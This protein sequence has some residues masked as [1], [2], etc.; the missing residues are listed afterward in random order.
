MLV[1][2]SIRCTNF[3]GLAYLDLRMQASGCILVEGPNEAG[4]SSVLDAVRFA[5][6]GLTPAGGTPES[7][8]RTGASESTVCVELVGDRHSIELERVIS[9]SKRNVVRVAMRDGLARSTTESEDEAADRLERAFGL[10][11]ENLNEACFVGVDDTYT[12]PGSRQS[13]GGR[14]W[15]PPRRY[16]LRRVADSLGEVSDF[17][18]DLEAARERLDL[19]QAG[20]RLASAED[21]VAALQRMLDLV[22]IH[23]ALVNLRSAEADVESVRRAAAELEDDRAA[24]REELRQAERLA[25]TR[26]LVEA[27]RGSLEADAEAAGSLVSIETEMDAQRDSVDDGAAMRRRLAV[28]NEARRCLEEASRF[29]SEAREIAERKAPLENL[30]ATLKGLVERRSRMIEAPGFGVPFGD[31]N[32]AGVRSSGRDFRSASGQSVRQRMSMSLGLPPAIERYWYGW[33]TSAIAAT[34]GAFVAL[35][36]VAALLAVGDRSSLTTLAPAALLA[37]AALGLMAYSAVV[38]VQSDGSGVEA[39]STG[40]DIASSPSMDT[41]QLAGTDEEIARIED[42]LAQSDIQALRASHALAIAERKKSRRRAA[43]LL[44][45]IGLAA[46]A[47]DV[48][49]EITRL[50]ERLETLESAGSQT[51]RLEAELRRVRT[52]R[53][54]IRSNAAQ[55]MQRLRE[56][57]PDAVL[58]DFPDTRELDA[59]HDTTEAAG[60]EDPVVVSRSMAELSVRIASVETLLEEREAEYDEALGVLSSLAEDAGITLVGGEVESSLL[61]ALPNLTRAS[62]RDESRIEADITSLKGRIE[63]DRA[64]VASRE[65]ALGLSWRD[66]DVGQSRAEVERLEREIIIRRQAAQIAAKADAAFVRKAAARAE[67]LG[68]ELL[69]TFVGERYFDLRVRPSGGVEVWDERGSCWL[70]IA[71]ASAGLRQQVGLVLRLARSTTALTPAAAGTPAF[72]FLDDPASGSDRVR[73]RRIV[74]AV[75]ASTIRDVFRQVFV[76]A[77]AGAL[78]PR[79]FDYQVSLDNGTVRSSTLPEFGRAPVETTAGA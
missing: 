9:R 52:R 76:F 34:G 31:S 48:D 8:V 61:A 65:T 32:A 3:K 46:R 12:S 49:R 41:H 37:A 77:V 38:V 50:E 25:A 74:E 45:Q 6:T 1:I 64:D 33:P 23:K 55:R 66:L 27:L 15:S 29:E 28:L 40:A 57:W 30:A 42:R 78:D 39:E 13:T 14:G 2:R 22:R 51:E 75:T 26:T 18:D 7:L 35:V 20:G 47:E 43:E 59:L 24:L 62:G 70:P 79:Q 67:Y 53:E 69:P 71:G 68:R 10:S 58:G 21:E 63:V 16:E 4:K 60:A 17:E 19:V 72:L 44:E 54:E 73:R 11:A 36:A 56:L 5:V